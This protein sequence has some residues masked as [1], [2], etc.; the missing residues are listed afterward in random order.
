MSVDRARRE[1]QSCRLLDGVKR[2]SRIATGQ[3]PR[4]IVRRLDG[5]RAVTRAICLVSQLEPLGS[6]DRPL[7]PEADEAVAFVS[8]RL[9]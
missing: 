8:G 5:P 7:D 6:G 9:E 2:E 1:G 3:F 4:A